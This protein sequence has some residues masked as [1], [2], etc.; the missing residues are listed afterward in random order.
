MGAVGVP[1]TDGFS[2]IISMSLLPNFKF[3]EVTVQPVGISN[4]GKIPNTTMRNTRWRTAAPKAL[5]D[6]ED[7]TVKVTYDPA[8]YSEAVASIGIN[9]T[10]TVQFPNGVTIASQMFMDSFKPDA[11]EE[12]KLPEATIVFMAT[13]RN[14]GGAEAGPTITA[15]TTTT[16]TTTTQG[17]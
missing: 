1:L 12:G 8:C 2:T 4:G 11:L 6:L 15:P 13:N 17:P 7:S 10:V 5:L 3:Y 14:S 9:Q 16:G